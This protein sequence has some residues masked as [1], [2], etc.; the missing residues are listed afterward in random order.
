MIKDLLSVMSKIPLLSLFGQVGAFC[1]LKCILNR[2]H[3]R[4]IVQTV[5][6]SFFFQFYRLDALRIDNYS[7]TVY[8]LGH[9]YVLDLSQSHFNP[10]LTARD[11]VTL[12]WARNSL[13]PAN[14]TF[15]NSGFLI[16][17]MSKTRARDC[18]RNV[19]FPYITEQFLIT[20]LPWN[21][22]VIFPSVSH[23]QH[24]L[25]PQMCHGS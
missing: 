12:S 13:M 22:Y 3:A 7:T 2:S 9:K 5:R 14:L 24:K 11:W 17:N 6:L 10:R 4:T 20:V 23:F 1:G 19:D 21:K 16:S 18:W 15:F 8:V 25:L